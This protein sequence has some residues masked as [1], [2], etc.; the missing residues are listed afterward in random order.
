MGFKRTMAQPDE[1][2]EFRLAGNLDRPQPE[3][4]PLEMILNAR[5]K[6][7][8]LLARE[9][10]SEVLRHARVSI[11]RRKGCAVGGAPLP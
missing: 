7:I 10:G 1:A 11:E 9:G 2:G 8:A 3:T 4:V 5:H 6:P